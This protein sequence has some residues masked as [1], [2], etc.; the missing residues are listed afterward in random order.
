VEGLWSWR[1]QHSFA[2]ESF[3]L[4]FCK[5]P[6]NS[7]IPCELLSCM[8]RSG[9]NLSR[10][11][12]KKNVNNRWQLKRQSEKSSLKLKKGE[13]NF[14]SCVNCIRI[15]LKLRTC[16]PDTVP[17]YI[18]PGWEDLCRRISCWN[19]PAPVD[20]CIVACNFWCIPSQC[21]DRCSVWI[22]II[23]QLSHF[24][25]KPQGN[26]QQSCHFFDIFNGF[27]TDFYLNF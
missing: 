10:R 23:F 4:Y 17:R 9:E 5:I 16:L 27:L 14:F 20:S 8:E 6:R 12:W 11:K 22:G 13:Y 1:L 18:D 2:H 15:K 26:F 19:V 24:R 21:V 7:R 3:A 25:G